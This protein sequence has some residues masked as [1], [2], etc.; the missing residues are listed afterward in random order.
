MTIS[1]L[2]LFQLNIEQIHQKKFQEMIIEK[3]TERE[4][5]KKLLGTKINTL[6]DQTEDSDHENKTLKEKQ[7][8]ML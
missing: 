6:E 2:L 1:L 3:D 7:V 5:L 8:K 4:K